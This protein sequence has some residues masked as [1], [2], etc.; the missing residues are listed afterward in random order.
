MSAPLVHARVVLRA[1]DRSVLRYRSGLRCQTETSPESPLIASPPPA[2]YACLSSQ[3]ALLAL[4][5]TCDGE[6][7][8]ASIH[9]RT[10]TRSTLDGARRL[11]GR[12]AGCRAAAACR[13]CAARRTDCRAACAERQHRSTAQES[14][15]G[16]GRH[17]GGCGKPGRRIIARVCWGLPAL[18]A[19]CQERVRALPSFV[20]RPVETLGQARSLRSGRSRQAIKRQELTHCFSVWSS[21][22]AGNTPRAVTFCCLAPLLCRSRCLA[23]ARP[24]L[25][26]RASQQEELCSRTGGRVRL[27]RGPDRQAC[28]LARGPGRIVDWGGGGGRWRSR[29]GRAPVKTRRPEQVSRAR[30]LT[31]R[32]WR[33]KG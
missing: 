19:S 15:A 32:A 2:P 17:H 16:R 3:P 31:R 9:E 10:S 33:P 4:T 21:H 5:S 1:N 26:V 13:G 14:A 25:P 24:Y 6:T 29:G 8:Q 28:A 22:L 23:L 27:L 7:P 18:A 20:R 11:Y 12:A 30:S